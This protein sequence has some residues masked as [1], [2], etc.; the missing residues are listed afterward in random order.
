MWKL[1]EH[2]DAQQLIL[3]IYKSR[4]LHTLTVKLWYLKKKKP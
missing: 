2:V 3:I 4:C 1:L